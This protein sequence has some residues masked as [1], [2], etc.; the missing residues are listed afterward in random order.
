[1]KRRFTNYFQYQMRVKGKGRVDLP[2][3]I[4][5]VVNPT[6]KEYKRTAL[7]AFSNTITPRDLFIA[8]NEEEISKKYK[9]MKKEGAHGPG[10]RQSA[11]AALW[12]EADQAEW[13][14]KAKSYTYDLDKYVVV[15]SSSIAL[16][17]AVSRNQNE[18]P[19]LASSSFRNLLE[20]RQLGSFAVSLFF[21]GRSKDNIVRGGR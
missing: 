10:V 3:N 6:T 9:S 4:E 14:E 19:D 17:L 18:F 12:G 15:S 8:D 21:A 1:M 20:S 2:D 16:T 7:L 5:G 11:I 13:A